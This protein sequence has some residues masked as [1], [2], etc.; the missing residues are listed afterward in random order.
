MMIRHSMVMLLLVVFVGVPMP[1]GAQQ[2][3]LVR[4][5][6]LSNSEKQ[7]RADGLVQRMQ[8]IHQQVKA[9]LMKARDAGD[10]IEL[11]CVNVKLTSIKGLLRIAEQVHGALGRAVKNGEQDAVLHQFERMEIAARRGEQYYSESEACVGALEVYGGD[12]RVSVDVDGELMGFLADSV[13]AITEVPPG[14][15]AASAAATTSGSGNSGGGVSPPPPV[16]S[17]AE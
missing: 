14:N 4:G 1:V 15:L 16:A 2:G 6:D 12:T 9:R 3:E 5:E 13:T 11:N 8:T 17:E 10:V 7:E